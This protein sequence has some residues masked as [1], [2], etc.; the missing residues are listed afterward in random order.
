MNITTLRRSLRGLAAVLFV[1]AL[2]HA[3]FAGDVF[4]ATP[5]VTAPAGGV[6]SLSLQAYMGSTPLGA[7]QV[8]V[9]FNAARAEF[10]ECVLPGSGELADRG[11]VAAVPGEVRILVFNPRSLTK[12]I[13]TV[14]LGEIRLRPLVP[15]G[16]QVALQIQVV[17]LLGPTTQTLPQIRGLTGTITVTNGGAAA[18][19]LEGAEATVIPW[20]QISES[21][22]AQLLGMRA[23]GNQVEVWLPVWTG[24]SLQVGRFRIVLPADPTA[25]ADR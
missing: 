12:P 20:Q 4:F 10:V 15:A 2:A 1:P 22:R 5:A 25:G 3:Q 16:Q 18:A 8:R 14:D 23:P 19:M 11:A 6:A 24:A 13:G 9:T 7:A 17:A 21:W